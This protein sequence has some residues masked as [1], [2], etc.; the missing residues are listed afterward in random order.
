MIYDQLA[1][2][3]IISSILDL[4]DAVARVAFSFGQ[5][6][7]IAC[8]TQLV[9]ADRFQYIEVRILLRRMSKCAC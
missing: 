6:L 8:C 7:C 1:S 3:M 2:N 4:F 9:E 5:E